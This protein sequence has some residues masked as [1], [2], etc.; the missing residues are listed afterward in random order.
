[1]AELSTFQEEL[2]LFKANKQISEEGFSAESITAGEGNLS[3][4]TDNGIVTEGTIYDVITSLRGSS[5]AGKLEIIKGELLINSQDMEEIKVAQS[6]GIQVN[7]YIIID[8]ELKSDGANL[9]LMDSTGTLTIPDGVTKIGNGAFANLSGLKTIIIP[10]TVKEIGTNAF[11]NNADLTRVVLQEGIEIIGNAAFKECDNLTTIDLPESLNSIGGSA[12]EGCNKLDNVI[13]PSQITRI[14][15]YTFYGCGKLKNITLPENLETI[16]SGAFLDCKSLESI[17]IPKKVN[18]ISND[19]FSLCTKLTNIEIAE[20]NT[21]YSYSQE[22]GMLVDLE[23]NNILFISSTLL[24]NITSFSIPE[25]ITNFNIG[26]SSYPNI[27]TLII[28]KSLEKITNAQIFPTS[29]SN[30]EVAEG[31]DSFIVENK[32]LYNADKTELIMCFTKESEV[33]IADET[34]KINDYAFIQAPNIENVNLDGNIATIGS[35]VFWN[36]NTKLKKVYIGAGVTNIEPI[37]KYENY[38]GTVTVDEAN[39]NYSSENNEIYNKDK[40][41]LIGIY[42][43]IQG[44][45]T[46]RSSV[47]KIGDRAF[48]AKSNMTEVILPAGLKEIGS[49][50]NYCT[51]LTEIYV[52]NS[53]EKISTGAFLNS[54]N[55]MHIRID[56]APNTIEGAPWGAISWDRAVEWLRPAE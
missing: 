41:E 4:V 39:P 50:F 13:I 30:V 21:K 49:S 8:G 25:G 37:F 48:H 45:Y 19:T 7:P 52:P 46:V 24:N 53:V 47:T 38:Y 18:T 54:T 32:C 55:L 56:K 31:N 28:P 3:Y 10:G 51:G 33:N 43:D 16:A 40:T 11:T 26:I 42:H 20:E 14:S 27:T 44:S 36:S 17:Y 22:S 15:G 1:M 2:G 12:F 9:A 35:Q 23:N 6:M 34:T 29:L 5:F